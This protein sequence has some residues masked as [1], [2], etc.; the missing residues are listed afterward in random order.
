MSFINN[1]HKFIF[2]GNARCGSTTMYT[3]LGNIFADDD[4]VW[5]DGIH[6][7]PWLYHMSIKDTIERYPFTKD[8]KK[9]CFVR[10][11]WSRMLSSY[12]EFTGRPEWTNRF[13]LSMSNNYV[14][15][16]E[17]KLALADL[18]FYD[19][20][21]LA[22]H[23]GYDSENIIDYLD[24]LVTDV[25]NVRSRLRLLIKDHKVSSHSDWHGNIAEYENF[26]DFCK[27]FLNNPLKN[28]IHFLPMYDQ[29]S[30][31]G[32]MVMDY[33][34]RFENMAEDFN[35][36]L[37]EITG[38][39]YDLEENHRKTQTDN[40]VESYEKESKQIVADYYHKDVEYFKY[41]I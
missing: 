23:Y 14:A 10:N 17:E 28:D 16:L 37:Y 36:I 20:L 5:E 32:E 34:G 11:P 8:Y 15:V 25:D 22:N 3:K 21:A 35:A 26:N 24:H 19:A 27:D 7:K 39:H 6:A 41:R 18:N 38:K 13:C 33:V 29:M 9:F 30:I 4:I 2:I 40:Y 1:T 12:N 31:D